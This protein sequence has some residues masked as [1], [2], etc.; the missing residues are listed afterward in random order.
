M[1]M[2]PYFYYPTF[3]LGPFT[4]HVWGVIVGIGFATAAFVAYRRANHA[5][6]EGKILLDW[7]VWI[8]MASFIGARLFHVLFYEWAYF[9]VHP[10]DIIKIWGGGLSSFG[11]FIG[12]ALVSII[13]VRIKKINFWPYADAIIYA[14]PLGLGI[15]RIGCF[16]THLH[17]GRLSNFPLAVAFPGGSRLDMG[18]LESI[19][20]FLI[21]GL[22][23]YLLHYRKWSGFY[24]PLTMILYGGIRFLLDFGRAT[25]I[26]MADTRYIGLTPAQYGTIILL[27]GG[28]ALWRYCSRS[29]KSVPKVN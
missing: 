23:F 2:I 24:L 16:V 5:G 18:L 11:G 6:L 29:L 20:G 22:F 14:F 10:Q 21:F 28:V 1:Y 7:A 13:F 25:D 26:P 8:L 9:R 3:P 19:V 12:A 27:L 15:G 4:I 17:I